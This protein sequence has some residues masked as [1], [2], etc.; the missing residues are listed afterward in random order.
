MPTGLV[1][2]Q[3]WLDDYGDIESNNL[4]RLVVLFK[5]T[6]GGKEDA[7]SHNQEEG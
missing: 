6:Q 1:I 5:E 4:P 2:L 7:S 3:H